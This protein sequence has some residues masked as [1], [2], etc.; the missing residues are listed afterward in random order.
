MDNKTNP[1]I[2]GCPSCG[3]G[4]SKYAVWCP[5]CGCNFLQ[6][7]LYKSFWW[8][9][10]TLA[11]IAIVYGLIVLALNYNKTDNH[12][13]NHSDVYPQGLLAFAQ[14]ENNRHQISGD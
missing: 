4:V 9:V 10:L 5:T 12:N 1:E 3:N 11:I 2:K 7:I 13:H 14:H 8:V 6:R